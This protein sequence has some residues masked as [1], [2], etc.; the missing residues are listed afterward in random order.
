MYR[1]FN[2]KCFLNTLF[3]LFLSVCLSAQSNESSVV[4]EG[5]YQGK[6]LYVQKF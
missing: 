2:N 1:N 3:A 5:H 4:I 6:N